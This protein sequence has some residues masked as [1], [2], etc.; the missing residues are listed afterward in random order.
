MRRKVLQDFANVFCQKFI[1]LPS[2]YDLA[3]FVKLGSG[4]A[5]LDILTGQCCFGN[6]STER[7]ETCLEHRAWWE[8]QLDKHNIPLSGLEFVTMKIEFRVTDVMIKESYGHNQSHADFWFKCTSE[9]RTAEASYCGQYE[10]LK[11]WGYGYYWQQ[12]YG[13]KT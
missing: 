5:S 7:L 6:G 9:I 8:K 1:D 3:V 2:G 12:L 10:G 4:T 11:K 13:E